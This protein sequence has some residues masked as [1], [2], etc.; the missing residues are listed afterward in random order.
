MC[1]LENIQALHSNTGRGQEWSNLDAPELAR[2]FDRKQVFF[3][4]VQK[5]KSNGWNFVYL[6][7]NKHGTVNL[8]LR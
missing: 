1:L 5:L 6:S 2:L 4:T 8:L 7:R 3:K